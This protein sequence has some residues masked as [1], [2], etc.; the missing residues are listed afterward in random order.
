LEVDIALNLDGG[1]SSGFWL[2]GGSQ[3]E[4]TQVESLI[5]VPAVIAVMA[6]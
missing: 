4:G 3:A 6:K 1:T 2:Q 5:P